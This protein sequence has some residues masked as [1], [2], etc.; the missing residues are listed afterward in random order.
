MEKLEVNTSNQLAQQTSPYLQQHAHNPVHWYP[1]GEQALDLARRLNKPILL[2][3]GYSACHWC[4]VMAHESF[5]DEATAEVMNKLYINI[6]VDREERP[7]LDRIYQMAH[8]ILLQR[9][10]G[11]PLTIM[12][13]PQ[14]Q[15]PFFAGTYFPKEAKHSM[16]GFIDVLQQVERFYREHG[17][18]LAQQNEQMCHILQQAVATHAVD[19]ALISATPLDM[20]RKQLAQSYDSEHGG[21]G[22]APKFPHPTNLD[23]LLRH[24]AATRHEAHTDNTALDMALDTLKAMARG[25]L[26][27]QLGGGFYRYSVDDRWMIPHFEKML[28]DNGALLSLY[29]WAWQVTGES[30]LARV[31]R[32]AARWVIQEM[33]SESGGYYASLDADSEGEEGK[34][35]TWTPEQMGQLLDNEECAVVTRYFGLDRAA[36]FESSWH[37]C[38]CETASSVAVATG[39][40]QQQ[41]KGHLQTATRK[42]RLAREQRQHPRRDEK[43]ICSWNGLMI[44]G[45]ATT[46]RILGIEDNIKSAHKAVDFIRAE[47]WQ[48]QRLKSCYT[49]GRAHLM[50]YLDDYVFLMDGLLELLQAQWRDV[51]M[52]FLWE[53]ADAVLQHFEDKEN[54]GFF[55][56]AADHEQL[57]QR[58]KVLM[59]EAIPAGNGVVAQVLLRLGHLT[60]E[61]RFLEAAQRTLL[62]A[63]EAINQ[64]P[65]AHNALL[66]ALEDYLF[67]PQVIVLRG[68]AEQ[69]QT[70]LDQTDYA[71]RRMILSIPVTATCLPGSLQQYKHI[72]DTVAY[73]CNAGQ[74]LEPVSD[75]E[76][77][78]KLVYKDKV[79]T[80][81]V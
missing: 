60:G 29:A 1:W 34:F 28:Y 12:L 63:W 7:D 80:V 32:Q 71:P 59:D 50:A 58:P 18:E 61:Q 53:L 40:S 43:I 64:F 9:G 4:H 2:S 54:G 81:P 76:A 27:D 65:S 39:L 56:T 36:N 52:Q 17:Q 51:D 48:Q 13:T 67:P 6:K 45:M 30:I 68:D 46:G 20:S 25:G 49:Q 75:K 3:I 19:A 41:V 37:L 57:I 8:Q 66:G 10:G 47:L 11:W 26:F 70:W 38:L 5:E 24:W 21:F 74:C 73:V 55:F 69:M 42:L 31:C 77:F 14:D 22:K 72:G 15:T 23:R 44:K 33:Q 78:H 16:P 79:R 35:Y 62:T